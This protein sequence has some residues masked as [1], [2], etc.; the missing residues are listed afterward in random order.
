MAAAKPL[1]GFEFL[2]DPAAHA[3]QSVCVLFGDEPYLKRLGV[4]EIRRA[5]LGDDAADAELSLTQLDG[6]E[7]SL[8][9]VKDELSTVALFGPGR[10]LVIVSDADDFVSKNR[11]ELEDYLARPSP[12]GVLLL[13]VKTWPATTKL[14]KAVAAGGLQIDFRVPEKPAERSAW[15]SRFS[16]W[17]IARAK[18]VHRARLETEALDR[19][20]E[21]LGDEV[22]L[23]DSEVAKLALIAGEG[24]AI[25][26]KLVDENAGGW[27]AKTGWEMI[28]RAFDGKAGE[29]LRQLDRLLLAGEQPVALLGQLGFRMRQYA[30]ATRLIDF[31][32]AEGQRLSPR[33]ALVAAGVRNYPGALEP[34]ER[35]LRQLGRERCRQFYR[36][37]LDAD[38]ALKGAS[39]AP[40]R[41]V[42]EQL[43]ARL[44]GGATLTS[45]GAVM[46]GGSRRS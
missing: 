9:D 43:I 27:R 23:L 18:T 44:A 14:Y 16:K 10:R 22:G 35:Q 6:D 36:W 33:D 25:T 42:L 30:A 26:R 20:Q 11:P 39:R 8:R 15:Q 1:T 29:A 24:A 17:I 32:D 34:A 28:D 19:L 5:V 13:D 2:A 46:A 3:P 31:A 45:G 41:L 37:L 4:M 12:S 7:T 21:M 38:L 40:S